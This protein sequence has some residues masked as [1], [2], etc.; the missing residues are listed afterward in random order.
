MKAALNPLLM[1]GDLPPFA[2][3]GPAHVAPA[4]DRLLADAEA[5]LQQAV[6][7]T[8]PA[9]YDALSAVLDVA[10]ERLRRGWGAVGHLQA[11][12]DTPALRAAYSENLPRVTEF[13]TKLGADTRL[14]TKYKAVAA[15]PAAAALAPAKHK[16]LT[17]ALR[18]FV[19]GGAELQGAARER[20]AQLQDR[21]AALSQQFGEHVLDATDGYAHYANA[22]ECE[23][24]PA[25]VLAATRAAA[26][27]EGREG[28]KL[29]LH[30]PAYIPVLQYVHN[31]TLRET[32]FRA[33]S[34]R[35]SEFGPPALDNTALMREL[36]ELRQE[37]AQLLGHPTYADV[38]LVAKMAESP[39][40]VLAF[41]RDLAQ[42]ARPH[43]ERDLAELE[44]FAARELGMLDLQAWDRPYA[45]EKLKQARYAFSSDEVKQYFTEPRVLDGLFRL[46]ETLFD[47]QIRPGQAS[48]WHETVRYFGV[49]RAGTPIAGFYIDLYARNGKSGGAW[50]DDVRQRWAR[51][52]GAGLQLPVAHLICNFAP[53]VGEQPALLTHDDLITLFHEFGHGLHHML[54]RVDELAVAGISGVEWDAAELPSQFMENFCWEWEV[55][56]KLSAHVQTGAPLP[57]ALFDKMIAARNFQSG[58]QMLRH[59]EYALF[60]M[61]LHAEA[62]AAGRVLELMR[63]VHDEVAL[64]SQPD[65]W[66]YPHS[67]SHIFDGG[68]AAGY[69]GYAWAEVLSAD[70][71]SAFE[72]AGL[73]DAATGRRYREAILEVGGSRP[74]MESFVAFR[75]REPRIDALLRHQGMA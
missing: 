70:A 17:D 56:S 31:R 5:A 27:A 10:V 57:R 20:F 12:A 30:A 2:D 54:T 4:V 32:L 45:S 16:A 1:G 42:R 59:C 22:A 72:E 53:P 75:G 35:A 28:H 49:E 23:G 58:L 24:L 51:P 39:A 29:T 15:G 67:F 62:G 18:D 50:M 74:A 73:F 25:D 43:A 69:Y 6:G 46:V 21:M 71:F 52:D 66:R 68:Y 41:V 48:V 60:D 47:V 64:V 11:V 40:Q 44:A 37:E 55:L 26:Q 9:D 7:D 33:H 19:L 38:S 3:I 63:A 61:R 13:Y 14:Y 36:I 8:V 65:F 34:T